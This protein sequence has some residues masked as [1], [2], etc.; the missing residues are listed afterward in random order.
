M[1]TVVWVAQ[2]RRRSSRLIFPQLKAFA[3]EIVTVKPSLQVFT[4]EREMG[5]AITVFVCPR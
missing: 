4:Y 1:P 5:N 3:A 2:E